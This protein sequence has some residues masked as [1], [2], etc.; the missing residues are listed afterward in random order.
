MRYF[1][2]GIT[3]VLFAGY[4]LTN[5]I[6]VANALNKRV[7][8]VLDGEPVFFPISSDAPA[9]IPRIILESKDR[10]YVNNIAMDRLELIYNEQGKPRRE[11]GDLREDYLR[12][13]RDIAEVVKVELK[14]DVFRLGF[15]ARFLAFPSD[16]VQLIMSSFIQEGAIRNPFG[17][18]VHV[19]DRMNWNEL[20]VNRWYRLS[21]IEMSEATGGGKALSVVFDV[22]TISAKRYEFGASS[23]TAFYDRASTYAAENIKVLFP[24]EKLS[25]V[26]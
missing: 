16:P 9:E 7:R 15:I 24:G 5:K 17:L 8:R 18:Q 2:Q 19:L 21:S 6:E 10:R 1:V 12:L 25:E 11:I 26:S 3:A 23:I 13:V 4:N 14:A 20:D 22:N